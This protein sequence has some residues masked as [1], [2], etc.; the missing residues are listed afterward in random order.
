MKTFHVNVPHHINAN[1]TEIPRQVQHNY[2]NVQQF[3]E[4]IN[5]SSA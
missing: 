1:L 4:V 2:R 5:D 3:A